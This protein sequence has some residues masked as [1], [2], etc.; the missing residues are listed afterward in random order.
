MERKQNIQESLIGALDRHKRMHTVKAVMHKCAN[1][2]LDA[3]RELDMAIQYCDDPQVRSELES[4]R[5]ALGNDDGI[6]S[7]FESDVPS[8]IA[9]L[10]KI[11]SSVKP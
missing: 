9:T 6:A 11:A 1:H 3:Y 7:H 4:L 10:Q 5:T 8:V 2:L